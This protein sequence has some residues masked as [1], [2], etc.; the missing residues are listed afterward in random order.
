VQPISSSAPKLSAGTSHRNQD[1]VVDAGLIPA[2]NGATPLQDGNNATPI[3]SLPSSP[4]GVDPLPFPVVIACPEHMLGSH[5]V[6]HG[7][8]YVANMQGRRHPAELRKHV[9]AGTT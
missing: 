2:R 9:R 3:A 8:I 1:A 5:P 6:G 4:A 7:G